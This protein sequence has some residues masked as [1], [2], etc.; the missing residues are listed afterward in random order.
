M[1]T[2]FLMGDSIRMGY[3]RY[4]RG[5]LAGE[6]VVYYPSENCRFAQYVLRY[7]HEWI[8]KECNP[9]CV[10]VVHGN[11]GLW[12]VRRLYGEEPL[13]PIAQY[14]NFLER[15]AARIFRVCPNARQIFA[16][17]TPVVEEQFMHP[18]QF[19]RLNK[20]IEAY[21]YAACN[22]MER[23]GVVVNDLYSAAKA[24]PKSAWSDST[25]L[26][27]PLGTHALGDAVARAIRNQWAR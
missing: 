22:V 27:T 23:L 6:A 18:E 24:L 19:M 14:A 8:E 2:V 21:N 17:T 11:A 1:K 12:D 13:L 9:A 26:Y 5:V 3:D 16:L 4:V 20:D 25:H 15:I 7:A 10:D